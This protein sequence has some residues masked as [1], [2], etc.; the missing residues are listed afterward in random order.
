MRFLKKYGLFI[1]G[2]IIL[3]LFIVTRTYH[4]TSLPIFTDEAIY[5]RWAQIAKNDATWRF[6]SLT[7]GKQPM[8]M[9]LVMVA[10]RIIKDPLLAGRMVSVGAGF[11]SIIGIFVVAFELFKSKRIATFSSFFY[12]IFPF[13][14][15][16]DRVALYDSL[17]AMFI[18][19]SLYFEILLVKYIRLDLALILGMIIGF[20]MLNKSS[21]DFALILIPFLIIL[22]NFKDRKRKEKFGKLIAL[23]LVATV[24]AQGIYS[25]LRLSPFYHIIGEKNNS[26]IYSFSEW[27]YHPFTF[28]SGNF[29]GLSSWL[30]GYATIPLLILVVAAFFI[31]TKYSREKLFLLMWFLVPFIGLALFGKVIYPRFILF[32]TMPL[33]VIAAFALVV[34][35]RYIR[36]VI[37]Q[38]LVIFVFIG[39]M[40]WNDYFIITNFAYANIPQSDREQFLTGWPSGQGVKET[41]AF[42]SEKAQNQKIFVGTEGTFGLM[43]YSLEIYLVDNPNIR[44]VGYWPI[45]DIPPQEVIENSKH[46]PTYFIFYQPCPSC[47]YDGIAPST[48]PVTPVLQK[49]R[50][51]ANSY[52]TLYKIH[53]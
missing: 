47:K 24:M 39:F 2:A 45:H 35:L 4:I 34:I 14:L 43:P 26:F 1:V 28:F 46:M 15:V 29:Q 44:I 19:W 9:W 11:L 21:A 37:T 3:I 27:I 20:G 18:I 17:V 40:L 25:V 51:D 8:F 31:T 13:S 41:I 42:L 53:P 6:I 50:I 49:Q 7:D 48:W 12:L 33:L 16:Y 38:V 30:I 23:S 10:L 22:F 52:Y 5:I 32:M 36:L